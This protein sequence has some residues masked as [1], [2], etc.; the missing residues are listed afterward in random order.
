[1]SEFRYVYTG[2]GG[3]DPQT[4]EEAETGRKEEAKLGERNEDGYLLRNLQQGTDAGRNCI[5]QQS[6]RH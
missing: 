6:E 2:P 4:S 1:M 3:I 5:P